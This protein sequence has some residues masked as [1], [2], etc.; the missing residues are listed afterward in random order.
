MELDFASI[1]N[2]ILNILFV[3]IPE[4]I[5]LVMIILIFLKQFEFIK[6]DYEIANS[7]RFEI[8]KI[9]V[10]KFS[11][12]VLIMSILSNVLKFIG[13]GA[14]PVLF[15]SILIVIIAIIITY[16]LQSV[17]SI[18]KSIAFTVLGFTILMISESIY[19]PLILYTM[20]KTIAE[21]NNS[22]L[23]NFLLSLPSRLIQITII[24]FVLLRKTTFMKA[25]LIK[26]II[27]NKSLSIISLTTV[28]FNVVLL[29]ILG[30]LIIFDRIL[31]DM[32]L[33]IQL[34][35]II[36]T[37]SFPFINILCLVIAIYFVANKSSQKEHTARVEFNDS[38]EK[39][40]VFASL[41]K[42]EEVKIMLDRLDNSI[43]EIYQR[44][45]GE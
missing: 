14:T 3:S 8:Q 26:P 6:V 28:I 31:I 39:I 32:P 25:N 1:F 7:F 29:A 44:R 33:Y 21:I 22:F 36:L 13:V 5:C 11:I 34:G 18:L 2:L 23:T 38:L 15:I 27:K 35:V 37:V 41:G 40:K 10:I 19:I 30:K 24:L 20:N 17:S 4:E 45:G 16:K 43:R 12:P 42:Y 9:E